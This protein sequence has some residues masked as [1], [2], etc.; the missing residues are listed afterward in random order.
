MRD[1]DD[2]ARQKN[3]RQSIKRQHR[4][5]GWLSTCRGGT[6]GNGN[7]GHKQEANRELKPVCHARI[8]A[9]A[10]RRVLCPS[11]DFGLVLCRVGTARH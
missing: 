7:C 1:S 6:R 4:L 8:I 5:C 3:E 2:R 11:N 10:A 9:W